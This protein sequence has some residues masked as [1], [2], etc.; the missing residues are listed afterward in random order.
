MGILH[1]LPLP[2]TFLAEWAWLSVLGPLGGVRLG[3]LPPLA[4]AGR[5][6]LFRLLLLILGVRLLPS[7]RLPGATT[8]RLRPTATTLCL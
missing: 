3:G 8:R 7:R 6:F 5:V 2:V 1:L 4:G